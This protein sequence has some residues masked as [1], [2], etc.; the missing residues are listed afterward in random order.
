MS[1]SNKVFV[2]IITELKVGN[3][4]ISENE[5]GIIQSETKNSYKIILAKINK[6]VTVLKKDCN[7]FDP[8]QTGDAYQKKVCNVCHRLLDSTEFVH[9]QVSTKSRVKRPSCRD[10]RRK[11]DGKRLKTSEKNKWESRKPKN[12]EP[13]ECPICLKIT[14]PGLTSKVVL[15]H[16]HQ[17]GDARGWICDSCNTGIGRFQDNVLLLQ[18]AIDFLRKE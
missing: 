2:S 7:V 14:I 10:C 9:N 5:I 11:I 17:T 3:I 16:D 15:D 12:Y 8:L 1:N 6:V 13:F 4:V 18:R